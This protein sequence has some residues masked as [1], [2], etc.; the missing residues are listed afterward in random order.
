MLNPLMLL[1]LLGLSVPII[2]HL[3]QRRRLESRLLA[4]LRFLEQEDVANAFAP[5]PRDLLQLLLRLLLLA[6]F[7]LAMSRLFI[8]GQKPGPRALAIVLD[9][10]MSMQ[11]KL[12]VGGTLFEQH[13]QQIAELLESMARRDLFSL[14]LVGDKTFADTGYS[15]DREELKSQLD[16]FSPSDGGGR[17]VYAAVKRSLGELVNL[18]EMN[19][20][21]ILFSDHQ[22]LNYISHLETGDLPGLLAGGRTKLILVAEPVEEAA[23]VTVESARFSPERVYLGSSSKITATVRNLSEEEQTVEVAFSEGQSQGESRPMTL[24]PGEAAQ[25]DLAH[26]FESPVDVGCKVEVSDDILAAD[27]AFQAP[28]RMRERRQVL[29]VVPS[30]YSEQ[31]G[32]LA[33]Y[34]GIDLLTYAINP[35]EALGLPTGSHTVIKKVTP[36]ALERVTLSIYSTVIL[37]GLSDLPEQSVRDL[38]AFAEYGGGV[39]FVLDR[40]VSPVRL[41]EVFRPLLGSFLLG[42]LKT[43][44][45]P[46]HLDKSEAGIGHPLLLPF[47]R[48][49]W[50]KPDEITVSA[51]FGLQHAG[52]AKR[53]LQA[54]NGDCLSALLQVGRGQIYVQTFSCSIDDSSF[55]RSPAFV[56]MVQEVLTQLSGSREDTSSDVIR[57]GDIH[58]MQ[59]PEFRALGGKV[60]VAGPE[61]F[62]FSIPPDGRDVRIDGIY[63]AGNYKVSHPRKKTARHRWLSV[64]PAPGESVLAALSEDERQSVFGTENVMQ[65]PFAE[66]A[67][68]FTKGRE[69]FPLM[70]I[71]V[72][73]ALIG[74]SASGAWLSRRKEEEE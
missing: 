73:L 20:A 35:E 29:L 66:L 47:I 61:S 16:G 64:N 24:G 70:M 39:C 45:V 38:A 32:M 34:A 36:N 51:Y 10:S 60:N 3:I 68:Q 74:E 44:D 23:N 4:T 54:V 17:N 67:G 42:A 15:G 65:I 69:L 48:E 56:P 18:K 27:N 1:G 57:V 7:V 21:L 58:Y 5:V 28:M 12:P 6:L 72:F 41:N 53:V 63:T 33:S 59:L 2:I 26:M 13:K 49:E 55:P 40:E 50:G 52:D 46:V 30:D 8:T 71:V 9:N 25:L 14:V 31:E 37:Y 62:E 43:P 19:T 11:R 22:R